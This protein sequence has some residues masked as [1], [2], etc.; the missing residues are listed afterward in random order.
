MSRNAYVFDG[1]LIGFSRIGSSGITSLFGGSP[2]RVPRLTVLGSHIRFLV[3]RNRTILNG[4]R[5]FKRLSPWT[6]ESV[7]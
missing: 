4:S 6:R 3:L 2:I 7:N 1:Q 5:I